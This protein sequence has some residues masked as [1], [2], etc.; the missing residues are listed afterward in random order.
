[1]PVKEMMEEAMSPV[2]A[3]PEDQISAKI[4]TLLQDNLRDLLLFDL[5][6]QTGVE[7]QYLL[8]VRCRILSSLDVGQRYPIAAL[9]G[10][11][12]DA[13]VMT[14]TLQHTW[15]RYA[16]VMRPDPDEY[17][18]RSR[19]GG[20]P[21][22]LSSAS[23]MVRRWFEAAGLDGSNAIRRLRKTWPQ[24]RDRSTGPSPAD[25]TT[26]DPEPTLI[27]VQVKTVQETVYRQLFK[28]IITGQ[29]PPGDRLITHKLAKQMRVS[30]APVREALRLLEAG[31]IASSTQKRSCVVN[32]LSVAS[33][34]EIFK[35]RSLLE[36]SVV[37]AAAVSMD[38]ATLVQ[39]RTIQTQFVAAGEQNDIERVVERNKAFHF[40]I[41]SR[42][43]MPI[44][45]GI[46]EGLWNRMSPYVHILFRLADPEKVPGTIQRHEDLLG[47]LQDGNPKLAGQYLKREM[48]QA[49]YQILRF[50]KQYYP[51]TT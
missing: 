24:A 25:G 20:G 22:H 30:Q 34:D 26:S 44:A 31:G 49:H 27:P 7:M 36:V 16:A 23:V 8:R 39:A 3:T 4:R 43:G 51:Q 41:Y 14:E 19:K 33:F 18:I 45:L 42:A 5:L 1:M 48:T 13:I 10:K 37:E 29:I 32:E 6:T 15:G 47:A 38:E 12:A 28:A 35:I 17:A 46:L 50:L 40:L 9:K 21:L 11:T 2:E